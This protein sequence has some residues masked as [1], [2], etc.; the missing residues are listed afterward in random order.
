[1]D[2]QKKKVTGER[3]YC[4]NVSGI[5]MAYPSQTIDLTF[6]L[7][8][9]DNEETRTEIPEFSL[10]I[11]FS[12]IYFRIMIFNLYHLDYLYTRLKDNLDADN[13]VTVHDKIAKAWNTDIELVTYYLHK[14]LSETEWQFITT[15]L[16]E[17]LSSYQPVKRYK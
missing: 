10:G 12:K 4:I 1:M 9:R 5:I 13:I 8:S 15:I 7:K 6:L 11:E 3:I 14:R 2:E 16:S 17:Q